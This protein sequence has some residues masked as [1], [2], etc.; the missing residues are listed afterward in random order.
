M[1]F[2]CH[3]LNCSNCAVKYGQ[4]I[5][6]DTVIYYETQGTM[7]DNN[8]DKGNRFNWLDY[9]QFRQNDSRVMRIVMRVVIWL[10]ISLSQLHPPIWDHG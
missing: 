2:H 9:S 5:H 6:P 3:R 10:C 4:H 7:Q 8:G 1:N